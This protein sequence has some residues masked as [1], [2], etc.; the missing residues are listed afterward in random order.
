[1][2][3]MTHAINLIAISFVLNA[4]AQ[5]LNQHRGDLLKN[6]SVY[7]RAE[8]LS[9]HFLTNTPDNP[10]TLYVH[11][12][13]IKKTVQEEKRIPLNLSVVID[14][15]GSMTG[16]KIDYVKK[17]AEYLI[18]QLSEDDFISIVL[19][20]SDV[21]ILC[22]PQALKDKQELIRKVRSINTGSST[23]LEGGMRKGF[24]L[25]KDVKML[26]GNKRDMVNRVLLL[27]DG[28]A[29]VGISDPDQLSSISGN[30]FNE[31]RI[32]IST[33][34]VGV[35]YNEDLMTKIAAQAGGKYYFISSPEK[36]PELFMEELQGMSAL[37]AKNV[38]LAI[39]LPEK[40][41]KVDKVFLY[42]FIETD[43]KVLI[44]FNDFFSDEQKSVVIQ[45]RPIGKL[46]GKINFSCSISYTNANN[47]KEELRDQKI[48]TVEPTENLKVFKSGFNKSA[49]EGF[50]L[51][52]SGEK[53]EEAMHSANNRNFI[54]AKDQVKMAEQILENHFSI[55]GE[56]PFLKDLYDNYKNYEKVIKDLES[57]KDI[58]RFKLQIKKGKARKFRTI[59]CPAF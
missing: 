22:K 55:F 20:D 21:E 57:E 18:N 2:K 19:Y 30:F 37:V 59:S 49:S 13:G 27:S 26:I 38:I 10:I 45:F 54:Q 7:F 44:N 6:G 14:R 47:P 46:E 24:E 41:L 51:H 33:F 53:F 56:H 15:S 1:M 52:A 42:N 28:L 8:P 17:A 5:V 23:N 3:T 58:Y 36:L 25:A 16:E 31:N 29:N 43:G 9:S 48:L 11:L 34:G 4:N 40:N 50:A 12:Q 32:S 39:D 35:D